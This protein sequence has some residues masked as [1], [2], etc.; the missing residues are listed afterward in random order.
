MHRHSPA[1]AP[2]LGGTVQLIQLAASM[3]SQLW[4]GIVRLRSRLAVTRFGF[5]R[6]SLVPE[7]VAQIAMHQTSSGLSSSARR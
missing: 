7:N 4:P 3:K 6:L 1:S 5:I 2:A